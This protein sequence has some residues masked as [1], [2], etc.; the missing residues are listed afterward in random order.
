MTEI[1]VADDNAMWHAVHHRLGEPIT[2]YGQPVTDD[3]LAAAV[4][5]A[6]QIRQREARPRDGVRGSW[7][8]PL[9]ECDQFGRP[10]VEKMHRVW[11][12]EVGGDMESKRD[13]E[14]HRLLYNLRLC[15]RQMN[16]AIGD[17]RRVPRAREIRHLRRNVREYELELAFVDVDAS[18]GSPRKW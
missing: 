5:E 11:G 13:R 4:E 9:I 1:L 12:R 2:L 14:Y 17:I 6:R 15:I 18:D 8:E 7:D 16:Q 3:E 10:M